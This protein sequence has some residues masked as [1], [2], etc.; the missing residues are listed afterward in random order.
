VAVWDE[1]ARE[2]GFPGVA[3][4]EKFT[5]EPVTPAAAA[6]TDW[7][8]AVGPRMS[9]TEAAPLAS[10]AV[11]TDVAPFTFPPVGAVQ[12]TLTPWTGALFGSCTT[13]DSG[14]ERVERTVSD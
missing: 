1:N 12:V 8:P 6:V 13:T 7:V 11:T 3:V 10:V 9:V 5:G 2:N 4:S 14:V